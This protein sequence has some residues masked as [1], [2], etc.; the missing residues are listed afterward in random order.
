MT[1]REQARK[2]SYEKED[3][4]KQVGSRRKII[5]EGKGKSLVTKKRRDRMR[6]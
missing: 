1:K 4:L 5:E 3:K 6:E 2:E